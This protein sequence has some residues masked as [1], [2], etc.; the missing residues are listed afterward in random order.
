MWYR[1]GDIRIHHEHKF[2]WL[3]VLIDRKMATHK[4]GR[5]AVPIGN[6]FVRPDIGTLRLEELLEEVAGRKRLLLD[7]KGHYKPPYL[8]AYVERVIGLLRKHSAESW[9]AICGQTYTVLHAIRAAAPDLEVRYSIQQEYQWERF[10]RLLQQGIRRTCM[11]YGFIDDA[12]AKVMEDNG[13]DLYCWTVDDCDA[14]RHLVAQGV[15]GIISN[16]LKMLAELHEW[17]DSVNALPPPEA[18][19]CGRRI[20][21]KRRVGSGAPLTP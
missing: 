1:G 17:V 15:D 12:K 20:S 8:E 4:P 10:L 13:V 14:A 16:D 3:P 2:R 6:Y 11:A 7:V 9:T 19:K 5:F 21:E 18:D